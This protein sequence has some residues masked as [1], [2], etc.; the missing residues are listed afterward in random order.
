MKKIV[1]WLLC[2]VV[3]FYGAGSS[4]SY[5]ANKSWPK[6]PSGISAEGAVVMDLKSG[7]ILY[8]KNMNDRKYPAS[9]TKIMTTY[10]ALENS[11]LSE[12]VTYSSSAT[13]GLEA[14]ASNMGLQPGEK[15]SM[16]D[17]LYGAMLPSANEAC[18]GIAE[19]IAGNV[20]NFA[21]MMN[22]KAASLG[23]TGT[24]FANPNGLWQKN[25]YTTPHDM[26]LIMR[27]AMKNSTFRTICS[28]KQHTV[29]KTNKSKKERIMLNHH[30][31][32]NPINYPK[33]GY[34]YAVCGKTGYTSKSGATLVTCAKKDDMELVCV[35]MKT[36]SAVQG[37]PNIYTDTIK[38]FN[39]C[40][41]K[42]SQNNLTGQPEL[43]QVRNLMFTNFS[44]FF[45]TSEAGIE[46][47]GGGSVILPK[48]VTLAEAQKSVQ[49]YEQPQRV[50]GKDVIGKLTYTYEGKEAGGGN[51]LYSRDTSQS[52]SDSINM[53]EWFEEAVEKA[54]T[55][56][57]PWKV[58]LLLLLIAALIAGSATF[59]VYRAR[60]YQ[61]KTRRRRSYRRLKSKDKPFYK[62]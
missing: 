60:E 48:G 27:A 56:A 29:E 20:K 9:I 55:P 7:M 57:F 8:E 2:A 35:V 5:A 36:K 30:A 38:L 26:A 19:H 54:N 62:K 31:M 24:H 22:N 13:L 10:L 52:L 23:C 15:I 50:N 1:I 4:T 39:Y 14:G 18:L 41:E 11:S 28:T 61:S 46:L 16:E 32:V 51:I 33:Y 58:V 17:S 37:E 43:Q 44:P 12:T 3:L 45:M 49:Y 6:G 34:E 40:F 53:D 47:D 25:H 42:F 21:K 59:V